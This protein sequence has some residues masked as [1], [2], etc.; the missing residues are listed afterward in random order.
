MTAQGR[1][2]ARAQIK[3][4][5][6]QRHSSRLSPEG[7]A[8]AESDPQPKAASGNIR[9]REGTGCE[10]HAVGRKNDRISAAAGADQNL[11]V[12]SRSADVERISPTL[13][14]SRTRV[15]GKDHLGRISG[16]IIWPAIEPERRR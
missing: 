15:T 9:Y 6:P 11:R 7:V 5:L 1:A 4:D 14:V 2:C 16:I 12:L 10:A 8:R 3:P 13:I